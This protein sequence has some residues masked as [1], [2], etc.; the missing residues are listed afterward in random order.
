M[1][2]KTNEADE[3]NCMHA[4]KRM[5]KSP[6]KQCNSTFLCIYSQYL[7]RDAWNRLHFLRCLTEQKQMIGIFHVFGAECSRKNQPYDFI[8]FISF[9]TIT[10]THTHS[11]TKRASKPFIQH[12]PRCF[13]HCRSLSARS[14]AFV[15]SDCGAQRFLLFFTLL[16]QVFGTATARSNTGHF[17]QLK[18]LFKSC[19]CYIVTCYPCAF[20]HAYN[21]R[22]YSA[23]RFQPL[24]VNVE[25]CLSVIIF[26]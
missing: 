2:R 4:A 1:K 25:K 13:C 24:C 6:I 15:P 11:H 16:A 19:Q 12:I 22:V 20:L 21:E 23:F 5:K 26:S 8:V 7:T 14:S 3:V 17:Y 18:V 10:T 9:V